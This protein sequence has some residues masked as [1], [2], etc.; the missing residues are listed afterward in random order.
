[1]ITPEQLAQSGKEDALQMAVIQ[2]AA[3]NTL[4][5]PQLRWLHHIP[6]GGMY[7]ATLRERQI[8]GSK[9]RALGLKKGVSDLFLPWNNGTYHGL[10]IEMKAANG[11]LS[12]E[13]KEFGEFVWK[14]GYYFVVCYCWIE[15][16]KII[17]SYLKGDLK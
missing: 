10:Y 1:M 6:N 16:T 17:E 13:Q 15:A 5:Y 14:N 9:M 12:T 3:L 11:R 2:W 4:T 7:G 8:R